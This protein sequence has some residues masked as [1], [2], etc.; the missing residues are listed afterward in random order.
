MKQFWRYWNNK[1]KT[2]EKLILELERAIPIILTQAKEILSGYMKGTFPRRD[3]T[4]KS[5]VD[6]VLIYKKENYLYRVKKIK[7][8]LIKQNLKNI[9]IS[10]FSLQELKQ[11]K[12]HKGKNSTRFTKHIDQYK[13]LFGDE[14]N[15]KELK[16]RTNKEDLQKMSLA[17]KEIFLPKYFKEE[18]TFHEIIKQTYWLTDNELRY[19]KIKPKTTWQELT[20][21]AQKINKEHIMIDAYKYR[22]KYTKNNK[23]SQKQK[24]EY[25]KKLELHIDKLTQ[26]INKINNSN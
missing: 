19:K 17:F 8:E 20:A 12:T 5:D 4:P 1:T 7:E 26:E 24:E 6:I 14:L 22:Q 16:T 25:L 9:S 11:G 3:L 13:H 21:Q 15:K 23:P 10:S 2:E 18:M